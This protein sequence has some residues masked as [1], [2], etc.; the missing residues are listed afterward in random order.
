MWK[1]IA[2]EAKIL[3]TKLLLL[4]G[5]LGASVRSLFH[6]DVVRQINK[7]LLCFQCQNTTQIDGPPHISDEIL[8][9]FRKW[10]ELRN[11]PGK[12]PGT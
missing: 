6:T 12:G 5:L 3:N 4:Q 1:N 8:D 7:I 10:M 2:Y 9:A 11:H